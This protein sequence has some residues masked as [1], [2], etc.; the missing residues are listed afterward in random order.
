[1]GDAKTRS[2]K[3]PRQRRSRATVDALVEATGQVLAREGL[4]RTTTRRIAERAGVSVGSLYQ[5]FPGREALVAALV[6]RMLEEDRRLFQR[7]AREHAR[8]SLREL[9]EAVCRAFVRRH[10]AQ[11]ALYRE[12]LPLVERVQRDGEV[13]ALLASLVHD[14]AEALRDHPELGPRS[15]EHAA[16]VT[17]HAVRGALMALVLDG[18]DAPDE[19][20]VVA[21]M[22]DLAAGVLAG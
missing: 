12:V 1:V 5:Y 16:F 17:L 7:V 6:E 2:R 19:D 11:R 20:A 9:V 10:L 14:F 13:R 3:Q 15:P 18:P 4:E 21:A 8:A 22:A